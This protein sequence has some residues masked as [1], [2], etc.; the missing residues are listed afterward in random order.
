MGF[1]AQIS[2]IAETSSAAGRVAD[3]VRG[4]NPAGAVP[5]GPA[6]MPGARAVGKLARVKQHWQGRGRKLSNGL[7]QYSQ[8]LSRAAQRYRTSEDAARADLGG[9]G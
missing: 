4:V 1:E 7:D 2:A 3:A 5:D 6:G 8:D 9:G